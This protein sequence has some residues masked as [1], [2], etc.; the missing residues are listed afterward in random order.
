MSYIRKINDKYIKDFKFKVRSGIAGLVRSTDSAVLKV[1]IK[2]V[3]RLFKIMS[4]RLV[5]RLDIPMPDRFPDSDKFNSFITDIDTDLEKVYN[6]QELVSSDVQN[7]VNFNSLER[8]K[9]IRNLAETQKQVYSVYIKSKMGIDGTTVIREDFRNDKLYAESKGVQINLNKEN[10]TLKVEES[11]LDRKSVHSEKVEVYFTEQ[12]DAGFN[13]FPN[14]RSLAVGSFWKR[15]KSDIHF[16]SK[17]DKTR[18]KSMMVDDDDDGINVG[19]TQFEAMYTYETPQTT[20]IRQLVEVELGN[21]L[22]LHPSFIMIDNNISIHGAY[23]T[24][25]S[26]DGIDEVINPSVKLVVPFR[27][28]APVGTTFIVDLEGNDA[29]VIPT[30]DVAKSFVYDENNRKVRFLA[31]PASKVDEYGKTGRYELVFNEPLRPSRAELICFFNSNAWADVTEYMISEYLFEKVKKITLQ[32]NLGNIETILRKK[33]YVF[34]DAE[35]NLLNE[36]RRANAVMQ[37]KGVK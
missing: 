11:S 14:N 24:Q 13:L 29:N 1:I 5:S 35:S 33:A 2:E 15:G 9:A 21:Y 3:N 18:Y 16:T 17:N 30:I 36:R 37:F 27:G 25:K 19:S 26:M 31:I 20:T 6:A 12:P 28:E 34:V 22:N 8:E 32:T 10:L 4:G 23:I 7:V